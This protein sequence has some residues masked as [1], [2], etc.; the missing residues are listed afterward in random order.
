M[1]AIIATGG[2]QYKVAENDLVKL[3]KLESKEGDIIQLGNV[4]ALGSDSG[5]EVGKPFIEGATISAEVVKQTRDSKVIIFKKKRR[6]NYRRKN[7]H[8]QHITLVR[9]LDVS[10]KG[11]KKVLAPKSAKAP[12]V[13]KVAKEPKVKKQ[14][15]AEVAPNADVK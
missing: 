3:E 9:I 15:A 13:E 7:G 2:K 1:Y 5:I 6:H 4:L 8:R 11:E 12:E 14:A 10:G